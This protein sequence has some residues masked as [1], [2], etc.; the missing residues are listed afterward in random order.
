MSKKLVIH[1]TAIWH[2]DH[3]WCTR[4]YDN[5]PGCWTMCH[6]TIFEAL[7]WFFDGVF[8]INKENKKYIPDEQ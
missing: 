2:E 3:K 6:D 8:M 7:R 4:Y 1:N 5:E